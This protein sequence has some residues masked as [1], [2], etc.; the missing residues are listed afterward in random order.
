MNSNNSILYFLV[1]PILGLID[2]LQNL[3]SKQ[4]RTVIFLF[5]L[6]F[7]FCFSVGTERVEGSADG[8]SMRMEFERYKNIST[9][10]FGNYL[11][12]Y[13]EFDTGAQD[14]YIVT[15][16][17]L[18]GRVTDNYHF[19]FMALALVFAFFQLKCLRYFVK[20]T[21]FT[22]SLICTILVCFFL[23]N[24]IYNINGARFWTASWIGLFCVFKIFYDK[25]PLYLLLAV[26][27]PMIHAA[28]IIFPILL[29]ITYCIKNLRNLLI[30]LFCISWVFSIVVE[31]FHFQMFE[32]INLPFIISKKIDFYTDSEYIKSLY[33]GSGFYWVDLFFKSFVRQYVNFL[34]LIIVLNDKYTNNNNDIPVIRF[35]L[36]LAT[37][38][39]FAMFVPTFGRRFFAVNYALV[40]YSFLVTFG[41]F[42]YQKL[43][44]AL[45]FVWLMNLFYL[46]KDITAVLD[47][48]FV[49]TPLFSFVKYLFVI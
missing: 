34:I 39:N 27:T 12:E 46:F 4:A 41:D 17:Y 37:V 11:S 14:I 21:N 33:Q 19:F 23:W 47:L 24:N 15:M 16:S 35:M 3:R 36:I 2:A 7:G 28:F 25:K 20:S 8:I 6:C 45:P 43:I 26:C 10:Q 29:V 9:A 42:R 30:L 48:G 1:S 13:F 32:N 40:A 31:D 22:N 44:Y 49:L 5:C 18:V 38:A